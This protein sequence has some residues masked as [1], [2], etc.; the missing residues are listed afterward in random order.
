METALAA[1]RRRL[2]IAAD[3]NRD[4]ELGIALRR[5]HDLYAAAME[6]SDPKAALAAEKERARLL[7]LAAPPAAESADP[8]TSDTDRPPTP[9]ESLYD[10]L[11]ALEEALKPHTDAARDAHAG[12]DAIVAAAT[13]VLTR[14][15]PRKSAKKARKRKSAKKAPKRKSAGKAKKS[16]KT[17]KKKTA[18]K[19]AK[20]RRTK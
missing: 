19:A 17:P 14:L 18:K 8:E 5:C 10:A 4:E 12:Y 11:D 15:K 2:T 7:G 1:A 20:S 3:Y 13:S 9:T 16:S 6:M